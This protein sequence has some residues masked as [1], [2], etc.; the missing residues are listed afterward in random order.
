MKRS[1][2]RKLEKDEKPNLKKWKTIEKSGVF[3]RTMGRKE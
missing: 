1:K 3:L 2:K